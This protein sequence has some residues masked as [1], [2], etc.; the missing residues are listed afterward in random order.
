MR[1][2]LVIEKLQRGETSFGTWLSLGDLTAARLLA[3][4]GFDW[5]TLDL[6]HSPVDWSTTAAI[7]AV[8]AD[9]GCV[10]L[11]RV[12]EGNHF[13][14]KRALD[15]GA[16]GIVVPMIES[17]EA[18]RLAV[19]A[20]KYPPEGNRSVGGSH[21]ALNFDADGDEYFRGANDRILVV[22]Q[23]ESPAGVHAAEEIMS[24]PGVNAIL[25]GPNDLRYQM[26]SAEGEFPTT[27]DHEAAIQRVVDAGQR[28]GVPVGLHVMTTEEAHRRRE[29]GMRYLP[30]GSDLR[31]LTVEARR[32]V[33][34]L[35]Q[36]TTTP[37]PVQY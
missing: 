6:E 20:A 7:M 26:R 29:Q 21:H 16:F 12:P 25:I 1:G 8:V 34:L 22:L 2:N 31:M 24:V 37:P 28:T 30:I 5:L 33:K 32:T 35:G 23:I 9:A 27:E 36:A 3:R 17:V 15:A 4:V 19:R 13:L 11:I 10:P 18:A 14:I